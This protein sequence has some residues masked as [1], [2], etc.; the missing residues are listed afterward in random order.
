MHFKLLEQ[1]ELWFLIAMIEF[2]I[3]VVLIHWRTHFIFNV[4]LVC[5]KLVLKHFRMK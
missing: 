5:N 4:A 2:Y 1:T 3:L